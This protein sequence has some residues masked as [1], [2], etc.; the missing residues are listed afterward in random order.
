[1]DIR[2]TSQKLNFLPK[3][4]EKNQ[5]RPEVLSRARVAM[6]PLLRNWIF[7]APKDLEKAPSIGTRGKESVKRVT[8]GVV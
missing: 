5:L 6:E 3:E 2:K 4:Q 7:E 1:M 8:L